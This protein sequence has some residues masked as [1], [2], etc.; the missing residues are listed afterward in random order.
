MHTSQSATGT[1]TVHQYN[2]HVHGL[3][4]YQ[5]LA[6]FIQNNIIFTFNKYIKHKLS[7]HVLILRD[8]IYGNKESNTGLTSM[9]KNSKN[10]VYTDQNIHLQILTSINILIH[11][12]TYV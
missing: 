3:H 4:L 6:I 7:K 5:F 1:A 12:T 8:P 11:P 2:I 10:F 9:I